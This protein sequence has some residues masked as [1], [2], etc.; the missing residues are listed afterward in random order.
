MPRRPSIKCTIY[1][2][3]HSPHFIQARLAAETSWLETKV[4]YLGSS[5]FQLTLE[6]GRILM[7][8]NHEPGRLIEHLECYS[9]WVIKYSTR[10]HLLGIA[11]GENTT[12]MFSMSEKPLGA[13]D[14]WA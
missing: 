1:S 8:H 4:D 2:A 7:V 3:G 5:L 13:C 11:S 9:E 6:D 14:M 10:Y 12:A